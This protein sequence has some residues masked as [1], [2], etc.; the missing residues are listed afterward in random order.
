[1]A[2]NPEKFVI[3]N[4]EKEKNINNFLESAINNNHFSSNQSMLLSKIAKR[5]SSSLFNIF[6]TNISL[7]PESFSDLIDEKDI[8]ESLNILQ[9]DNI[10][11]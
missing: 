7:P 5:I 11:D 10:I 9:S 3:A 4:S 8:L 6:E 2:K 1:M